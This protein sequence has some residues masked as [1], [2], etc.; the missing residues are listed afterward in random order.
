MGAL[1]HV[2][3]VRL[4]YGVASAYVLAD[5]NDK[6]GKTAKSIP[7]DEEG[8]TAK[9]GAA[10]FE[11]LLGMA[12]VIPQVAEVKRK[13]ATTFI[14]LGVIPFIVHPIDTGVHILMD[15]TT[16]KFTGKPPE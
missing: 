7:E 9:I 8:R 6:A 11:S 2:N 3:W 12:K 4:S 13:W 5:T 14:G 10:A 16:R 1:V 15:N